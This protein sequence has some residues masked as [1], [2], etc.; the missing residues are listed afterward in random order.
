MSSPATAMWVA[1]GASSVLMMRAEHA[2]IAAIVHKVVLKIAIMSMLKQYSFNGRAARTSQ[3][4]VPTARAANKTTMLVRSL[5]SH[6]GSTGASTALLPSSFKPIS[7]HRVNVHTSGRTSFG[8]SAATR[9]RRRARQR[10]RRRFLALPP[11]LCPRPM[12]FP[13]VLESRPAA[14]RQQPA[15]PRSADFGWQQGSAV[16]Q[17]RRVCGRKHWGD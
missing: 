9:C 10:H 7:P 12:P 3:Q 11:P 2:C 1:S 5:P 8:Q 13:A 17:H 16:L 6:R 14:G 4:T 15:S